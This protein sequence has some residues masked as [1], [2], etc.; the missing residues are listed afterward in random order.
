MRDGLAAL[1]LVKAFADGRQ[2]FH[3]FGDD[4]QTGIIG[5]PPD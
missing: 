1:N 2:K 5:Q 3:L 4:I